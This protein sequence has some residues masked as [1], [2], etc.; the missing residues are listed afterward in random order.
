MDPNIHVSLAVV[1]L[2]VEWFW[3]EDPTYGLVNGS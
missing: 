3:M 1:F 2:G